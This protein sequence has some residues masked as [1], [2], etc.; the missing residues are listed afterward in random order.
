MQLISRIM[1]V[2]GLVG[3]PQNLGLRAML[4]IYSFL[5]PP[6]PLPPCYLQPYQQDNRAGSCGRCWPGPR[7][8]ADQLHA[9]RRNVVCGQRGRVAS[10]LQIYSSQCPACRTDTHCDAPRLTVTLPQTLIVIR[11]RP[12]GRG[13]VAQESQ[14]R[15]CTSNSAA[16]ARRRTLAP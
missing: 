3:E 12:Q 16:A 8:A 9:R 13:V 1:F 5:P 2:R 10:S 4:C 6:T 14:L 11:A 7:P 15:G